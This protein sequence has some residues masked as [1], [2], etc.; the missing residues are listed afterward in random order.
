MNKREIWVLDIPFKE[1]KE[2]RGLRPGVILI[3]TKLG[4]NIVVPLTENL[5]AQRF[6]NTIKIKKSKANGLKEDSVALLFH[7]QS[8]DK[9]R[10]VKRIGKLERKY[11]EEIKKEI[12]KMFS[13]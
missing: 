4:L 8:L 10:F 1:G 9:R 11:F 7:L 2:Q 6:S 13:D 12:N 3:K 5:Q